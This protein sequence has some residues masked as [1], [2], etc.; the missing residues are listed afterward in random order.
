MPNLLGRAVD[1][2]VPAAQGRGALWPAAL[3]LVAAFVLRGLF[4]SGMGYLGDGISQRVARD[5]RMAYFDKLQ[6]LEAAYHDTHHS[7]DLI[8]R[9]MLDLEGV[10]AFVE[11]GIMR[12]VMLT[13][14]LAF[15]LWRLPQVDATLALLALSFVP[16]VA[17]RAARLGRML[18][19]T[20][21]ALQRMMGELARGMEESLQGVRVVRV[22]AAQA[23]EL[24]KFD[25]LAGAA[26]RLSAQRTARRLT[27]VSQMTT[28]FYV[29][30]G[31]VLWIGAER[32]VAGRLTVGQLAEVMTFMT[33]L[34]LPVRQV[35]MVFN[36]GARAMSSG[37]RLFDVLDRAPSIA[38]EPAA[39]EL[40]QPAGS[41]RFENVGFS[42]GDR[43][44]LHDI[45]FELHPGGM[46]G[47]VGAPGSGKS[48]IVQLVARFYDV[49]SGRITIDG[50]D[51]RKLKLDSLREAVATVQQDVFLFDSSIHENAAYIVPDASRERIVAALTDAQ[52]HEHVCSLPKGYDTLV[53]ERGVAL[54]GGQRQRLAIARCL[55]G[56]SSV[57]VFDDATSALDTATERA[58]LRALRRRARGRAM[59]V[60]SHRLASVSGADEILVL[61][62]GRVV[63]RGRHDELLSLGGHYARAWALQDGDGVTLR[64]AD[65]TP[66]PAVLPS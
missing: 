30:M 8:A 31:L 43:P 3:W 61:D 2:A 19:D 5:L 52:L 63:E 40:R 10:R 37:A 58:L 41:L 39:V 65:T 51:I 46:L 9:G 36:A 55:V 23:F 54:S 38:E 24:A 1:L 17:W 42:Y 59:L 64:M 47:I 56:D 18:R 32:I 60:A 7:G 28:A 66:S 29:A 14:M 34:Q 20:W 15:G 6:Q 4:T 12:V 57:M 21:Y 49:S 62:A 48:T 50:C 13:L 22:F 33:V 27:A 26:F 11:A 53:G 44:V 25:A 16:F 45:S 35:A